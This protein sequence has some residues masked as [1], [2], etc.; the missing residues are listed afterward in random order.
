[1][2]TP[3][4]Q[5]PSPPS[6]SSWLCHSICLTLKELAAR[7]SLLQTPGYDLAIPL[8][9][10]ASLGLS[11]AR[12]G[13]PPAGR[14]ARERV[15]QRGLFVSSS[16]TGHVI[17]SSLQSLLLPELPLHS[18]FYISRTFQSPHLLQQHVQAAFLTLASGTRVWNQYPPLCSPELPIPEVSPPEQRKAPPSLHSG[19]LP[20]C[21]P[22]SRSRGGAQ[23]QQGRQRTGAH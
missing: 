5:V 19:S 13:G 2:D 22:E 8:A 21:Y 10:P 20:S 6:Q 15:M 16:G 3:S 1:M 12:E 14:V 7:P 11:E 18:Q 9:S 23:R 4:G 17:N